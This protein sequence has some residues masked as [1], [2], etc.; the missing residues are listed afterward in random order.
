[1]PEAAEQPG[2]SDLSDRS[3]RSDLSDHEPKH[4]RS[5]TGFYVVICAVVVLGLFGFWFWKTWTIWWFDADEARSRQTAAAARLGVPVEIAVDLPPSPSGSGAAGG[6]GVRLELVL[7][8]AGRFRMGSPATEAGR[9]EDEKQHWVKITRPFYI[10]KHEVT[11]EQW[12]KVMG[13][14]PSEFKGPKNPVENVSWDDC[15]AFIEKLNALPH[16]IPLPKGEGASP[17]PSPPG[18][19]A[20]GEGSFRLPTEAEWEWACRAGTRTRFSSGDA[21]ASLADVAWFDANSGNTTHPVGEKKPN[22]WGLHD[23]HGNVWEWCG[24]WYGE[25]AGGAWAPQRDPEGPATGSARVLRGGA[26][27]GIPGGCRSA[28]RSSPPAIRDFVIGF[29]VAGGAVSAGP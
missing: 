10:G 13:K 16:P 14:N 15:R 19:G 4:S 24:D 21:D 23:L 17:N 27:G 7:V 25:Y 8:P 2:K 28:Y 26:W 1:M 5:L 18:R 29:R 11:Q 22:A 3:D 6:G 20:R 12:E 9:N